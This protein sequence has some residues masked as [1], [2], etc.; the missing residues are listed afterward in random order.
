MRVKATGSKA[1]QH[2]STTATDTTTL[3]IAKKTEGS[4]TADAGK[5]CSN[6]GG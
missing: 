2:G 4:S 1:E 5:A 6:G 3:S